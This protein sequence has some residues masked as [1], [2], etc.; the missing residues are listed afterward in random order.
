MDNDTAA[1]R[2]E[3]PGPAPEPTAESLKAELHGLLQRAAKVGVTFAVRLNRTG[4]YEITTRQHPR[5]ER[6]EVKLG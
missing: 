6:F 5:T 1:L 2:P 3:E 4:A